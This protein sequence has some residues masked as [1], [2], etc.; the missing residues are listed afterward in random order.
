LIGP[1]KLVGLIDDQ[2]RPTDRAND[3]RSD[4]HYGDVCRQ[5]R[6]ECYPQELIDAFPGPEIDRHSAEVWFSRIGKLGAASA[7]N[8]SAIFEVLTRADVASQ[9]GSPVQQTAAARTASAT[10]G[11]NARRVPTRSA[12]T[13]SNQRGTAVEETNSDKGSGSSGASGGPSLHINVQIHISADASADQIDQIFASM[14]RH[15]GTRSN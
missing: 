8:V 9:D 5:I 12:V 10:S 14:A 1:L 3:W 15:L 4:E 6:R 13:D 7:K 11:V 2:S